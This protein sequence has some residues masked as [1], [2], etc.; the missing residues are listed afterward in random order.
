MNTP[1]PSLLN[2]HMFSATTAHTSLLKHLLKEKQQH[3]ISH[4]PSTR[5]SLAVKA[6]VALRFWGAVPK[7]NTSHRPTAPAYP[8]P[9]TP[10]AFTA[11]AC[12]CSSASFT[13][14]K[15]R[16]KGVETHPAPGPTAAGE[17]EAPGPFGGLMPS[18]PTTSRTSVP[19]PMPQNL[20]WVNWRE[21]VYQQQQEVTGLT[22]VER[23][24]K[25]NVTGRTAKVCPSAAATP[26]H[27]WGHADP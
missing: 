12:N 20:P 23:H 26:H 7:H 18:P 25:E 22:S 4:P 14:R 1:E 24:V 8:T 16:E 19:V 27:G 17:A 15:T 6:K 3:T 11:P 13:H 5:H 9:V 10:T 21:M 2:C